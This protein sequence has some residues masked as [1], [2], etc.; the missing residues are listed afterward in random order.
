MKRLQRSATLCYHRVLWRLRVWWHGSGA[1]AVKV[2]WQ[3]GFLQ[4]GR[5]LF[6]WSDMGAPINGREQMGKLGFTTPLSGVITLLIT[7]TVA[8]L[9]GSYLPPTG[10]VK[11]PG[12]ASI[13]G[14]WV[15]FTLLSWIFLSLNRIDP[16]IF[17][18]H[19]RHLLQDHSKTCELSIPLVADGRLG[20][21]DW[22]G[23]RNVL[24]SELNWVSWISLRKFQQTPGTY[25]R[26]PK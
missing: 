24:F 1:A 12:E 5:S 13:S 18:G 9:V 20:S 6:S 25:R 7:V 8:H 19:S 2:V 21:R 14:G 23:S 17:L 10:K 3:P 11:N 22:T 4:D 16:K 26:Y 15:I